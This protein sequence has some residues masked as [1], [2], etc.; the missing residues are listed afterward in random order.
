MTTRA[1]IPYTYIYAKL[2]KKWAKNGHFRLKNA[3]IDL[4]IGNI[5][6]LDSFYDF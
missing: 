2:T 6:Y 1:Q 5:L 4:K 3:S